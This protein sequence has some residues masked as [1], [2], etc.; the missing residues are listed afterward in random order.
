M[1]TTDTN[2]KSKQVKRNIIMVI[3]AIVVI[4][5]LAYGYIEFTTEVPIEQELLKIKEDHTT[6]L[7]KVG[8]SLDVLLNNNLLKN[9]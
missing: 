7:P 9:G 5:I 1:T 2:A 3:G 8:N 4:I 6:V